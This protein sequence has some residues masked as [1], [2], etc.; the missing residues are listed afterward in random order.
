[1]MRFCGLKAGLLA[2]LLG[3]SANALATTEVINVEATGRG[4]DRQG[5]VTAA[6]TEALGSVEGIEIVSQ[7]DRSSSSRELMVRG[8]DGSESQIVLDRN[9][10][11]SVRTATQGFVE[12]FRILRSR[13]VNGQ[14]EVRLEAKIATFKAPGAAA[15][16][17]RRRIAIYPVEVD[18]AHFFLGER[19]AGHE[20]S[21]RLTQRLVEAMTSAR[22][23]AVLERDH[24]EAIEEELAFLSD[25]AVARREATRIGEAIGADYLLS[26]RLV[27]MSMH[28]E[29]RISQLTSKVRT[30]LSG[31]ITVEVRIVSTATRQIM[32]ADTESMSA[33][34]LAELELGNHP[35]KRGLTHALGMVAERLTTRAVDAIY[36]MRIVS[37]LQNGDVVLNQGSGR[38]AQGDRLDVFRLGEHLK[39]P[40]SGESLGREETR[41]GGLAVDRVTSKVAYAAAAESSEWLE[42]AQASDGDY[43]VRDAAEHVA[44]SSDM[45]SGNAPPVLLPQD[46]R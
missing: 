6:L 23:F 18:G 25:P 11:E 36:P 2:V 7:R 1:M 46:R 27:D 3:L 28:A 22:R 41:V 12:G 30:K 14:V 4:A 29:R 13:D 16:S 32:W 19:Y 5:A 37:I 24:P 15:H 35:A 43:V 45:G 9:S 8:A 26:A 31:A 21:D 10:A 34:E 33:D 20:V 17:T 44:P 39:D 40:Y 38:L 42:E